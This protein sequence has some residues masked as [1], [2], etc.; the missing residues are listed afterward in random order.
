MLKNTGKKVILSSLLTMLALLGIF[1]GSIVHFVTEI[2]WYREVGYLDTYLKIIFS[3]FVLAVPLFVIIFIFL[4]LYLKFIQKKYEMAAA[5]VSTDEGGKRASKIFYA[6]VFA[7]SGI[8]AYV[9]SNRY[10]M[11]ILSYLNKTDFGIKDPIFNMELSFFM[12]SFPLIS[13]VFSL[14]GNLLVVLAIITGA[15]FLILYTSNP[16]VADMDLKIFG[17]IFDKDKRKHALQKIG[18]ILSTLLMIVGALL[19]IVLAIKFQLSSFR[20]LYS[21]RGAVFGAGYTD[22]NV[23]M[24]M[25]RIRSVASVIVAVLLLVGLKGKSRQKI[26]LA[27]LSMLLI[28][29]LLSSGIEAGVQMVRVS[30]NE[31]MMERPFIENSINYTGLAYGLDQIEV[32]DFRVEQN[33]TKEII[34]ANLETLSNIPI[35]DERPALEAFNQLQ[36]FRGYYRF[37]DVDIDR[38]VIDGEIQQIFLSARELD[39]ER[40][41]QNAQS[42]INT[43]LKYTHGYGLAAA[44][45]SRV[46]RAG[47]P[48]MVVQDMPVT[49]SLESLQITHPQIYFGELTNDYVI[50]NT[51]ESEFDYPRGDSNETNEYEGS[52]GIRMDLIRRILY[53]VKY[54]DFK[55]LISSSVHSESRILTNRNVVQRISKIAPFLTFEKDAYAVVDEGR[56]YFVLDGY[57]T[58]KYFPYSEPF[59]EQGDNYIRN[60]VKAVVDAYNGTVKF[61]ISDEKDPLIQTYSK[62][63]DKMFLPMEQ[64]PEGIRAHMRY[65]ILLFDV[66]SKMYQTFHATDPNIFY[67]REDQWAI[68]T[69]TYHDDEVPMNPLYFTYKLPGEEKA[70]FLLSIPFT[71]RAK[72]TLT[73]F[74]VARNDGENYGKLVL[75]RFPK[76]QSIIGPQQIEAQISNNDVISRDL[77]LWNSQGSEVIRGHVMTIP[78]E[79]SILY[80]EPLYIRASSTTAIP[81]VKRIIV[82]YNGN[83]VMEENLELALEKIFGRIWDS[84][85]LGSDEIPTESERTEGDLMDSVRKANELYEEA[86]K[87]LKAGSL[88]EYERLINELGMILKQFN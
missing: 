47:Q 27:G 38:Y 25:N 46:N 12:F 66:V 62:I 43:K 61:Y 22:V 26:F 87:A 41:D 56:I 33:L 1:F 86:Q 75:Y 18:R 8:V 49:S 74:L 58:S 73:A 13:S 65:P 34:H 9:I 44:P 60:S 10:W 88:S 80:I 48:D 70:E 35:N 3:K 19:F 52:A 68:P 42:W 16:P 6:A 83:I 51:G 54:S 23:T 32:K 53:S 40:L 11:E 63:F 14:A 37:Y 21:E 2:L 50:V 69:E 67:N 79:N 76:D 7:I 59:N 5:A 31:L 71:P 57:T 77:S 84:E 15:Y 29:A 39:K 81:E 24:W 64:M 45:A 30:P 72:Q 78:L 55:L 28:T 17:S 20:L 82:A 4:T 85:E 36:G